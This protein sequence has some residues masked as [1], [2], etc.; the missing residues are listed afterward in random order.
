MIALVRKEKSPKVTKLRGKE[1]RFKIGLTTK[2]RIDSASPPIAKVKSPPETL[3]PGTSCAKIKSDNPL[4]RV[5]LK[6]DFIN[7]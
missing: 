4:K 2:K 6:T 5:F 7:R 3:K 1:T